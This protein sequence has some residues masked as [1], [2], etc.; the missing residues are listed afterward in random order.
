MGSLGSHLSGPS[1]CPPDVGEL[2]GLINDALRGQ[3][4]AVFLPIQ[5]A[6]D[7]HPQDL[8]HKIL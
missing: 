2:Y 7:F 5:L 8:F 6:V 1:E 4:K 3:T